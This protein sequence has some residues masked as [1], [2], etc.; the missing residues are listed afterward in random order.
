MAREAQIEI[1]VLGP[2]QRGHRG[3]EQSRGGRCGHRL[4][5]IAH[6]HRQTDSFSLFFRC[7]LPSPFSHPL[8]SIILS[9][10]SPLSCESLCHSTHRP[11][12][13]AFL[14]FINIHQPHAVTLFPHRGRGIVKKIQQETKKTT[15]SFLPLPRSYR[16]TKSAISVF[17][18]ERHTLSLPS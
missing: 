13:T 11:S 16:L 15:S 3:R 1:G 9:H 12:F 6:L 4:M 5:E 10:H 18:V 7:P 14:S 2:W 8:S 17:L